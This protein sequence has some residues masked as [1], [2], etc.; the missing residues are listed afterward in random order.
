MDLAAALTPYTRWDHGSPRP[1][2]FLSPPL[3]SHPQLTVQAECA[4]SSEAGLQRQ[5]AMLEEQLREASSAVDGAR[6]ERSK[7]QVRE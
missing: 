2:A 4:R 7:L 5:V 6:A 3:P 1:S